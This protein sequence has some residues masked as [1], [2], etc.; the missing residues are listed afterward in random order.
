MASE[1][2]ARLRGVLFDLYGT[3]VDLELDEADP[4]LWTRLAAEL[5][6]EGG[7]AEG[8]TLR[9]L[10]RELC[11]TEAARAGE[12]FVL[13][14]VFPALLGRCGLAATPGAVARLA[15]RFRVLST[16]SIAVK[17]GVPG[18]LGA[19]RA[20]GCRLA[21]V[22][23]TEALL[24]RVDLRRVELGGP[25]DA[26]LLSSEV[27]LRKPDPRIFHLALAR[28]GVDPAEAV[29]VSNDLEADAGGARAA[30]LRSVL[31]S[32]AGAPQPDEAPRPGDAR[33]RGTPELLAVLPTVEA[34]AAALRALGW[35]P[36]PAG[37]VAT[38]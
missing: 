4:S 32:P 9:G 8:G 14:A 23:N 3:L 25:F 37:A 2:V 15:E 29:V 18:L 28:I 38:P 16:R 24:T 34:I 20:S 19:L 33:P 36:R 5:E 7:R 1:P 10:Y 27:G 11:A 6:A 13:D 22:S 21:L 17:P 31:L 12:G 26:V 35:R 30:G